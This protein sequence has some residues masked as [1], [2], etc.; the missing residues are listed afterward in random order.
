MEVLTNNCPQ[1]ITPR[2]VIYTADVMDL[3]GCSEPSA[4]RLLRKI[5]KSEEKPPRAFVSVGEFCA[6]TKLKEKEVLKAINKG[7]QS[8]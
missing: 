6:Y 1:M 2:I 8:K 3:L 7:I 5:R 4:H